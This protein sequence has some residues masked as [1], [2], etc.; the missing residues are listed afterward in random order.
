M[1]RSAGRTVAHDELLADELD[2][3]GFRAEWERLALAREVAAR[4]VAYR[5]DEDI[6]QTELARRLG[7]SQPAAARLERASHAPTFDTLARVSG[8]LSA[9]FSINISP[10][11]RRPK[12]LTKAARENAIGAY[13]SSDATICMTAA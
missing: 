10:A 7:I 6:T 3:P 12:Q 13:R 5:Y 9:E 1:T 2:D 8:L 4:L 11:A